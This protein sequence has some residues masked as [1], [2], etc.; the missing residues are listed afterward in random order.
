VAGATC[1][2]Q[3]IDVTWSGGGTAPTGNGATLQA[4]AG[5]WL[6]VASTG[7]T[8]AAP[9][10]MTYTW[11]P[12]SALPAALLFHGAARELTFALV[13]NGASAG[14]VPAQLGTDATAV[15]IR[16]RRP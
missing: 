13:P 10:V 5:D 16:Y 8:A 2:I 9:S 1:P 4:W 15:T 7:A 14:V 12:A 6:D 11:T 3:R